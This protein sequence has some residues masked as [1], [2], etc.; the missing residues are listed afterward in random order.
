M[1]YRA[2]AVQASVASLALAGLHSLE[3]WASVARVVPT[4]VHSLKGFWTRSHFPHS[5]GWIFPIVCIVLY[6]TSI[7]MYRTCI[8]KCIHRAYVCSIHFDT[9]SIRNL[10]FGWWGLSSVSGALDTELISVLFVSFMYRICIEEV[11]KKLYRL[12]YR[13][14][15]RA[16][17]D[18]YRKRIENDVSSFVSFPYRSCIVCVSYLNKIHMLPRP[19]TYR[20]CIG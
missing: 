10:G 16:F 18:Q 6:R 19:T 8:H 20:S 7:V 13:F 9:H 15:Y 4:R 1:R 17:S 5:A 12:L 11:S 3:G 14:L 2:E